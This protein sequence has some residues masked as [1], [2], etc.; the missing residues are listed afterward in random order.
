MCYSWKWEVMLKGPKVW[1]SD[2]VHSSA[3]S[4]MEPYEGTRSCAPRVPIAR[5]HC[6]LKSKHSF[7]WSCVFRM[8]CCSGIFDKLL[9]VIM[10]ALPSHNRRSS[11]SGWGVQQNFPHYMYF[12]TLGNN[13]LVSQDGESQLVLSVQLIIS[14]IKMSSSIPATCVLLSPQSRSLHSAHYKSRRTICP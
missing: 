7:C 4:F 3:H 10:P 1:A 6:S 9:F 14:F 12:K 11:V 2:A 13:F 5:H 8:L